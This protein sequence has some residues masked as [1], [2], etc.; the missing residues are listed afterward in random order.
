M[1]VKYRPPTPNRQSRS[2]TG[3]FPTPA[4]SLLPCLSPESY[5]FYTSFL[6]RPAQSPPMAQALSVL[7]SS[8]SSFTRPDTPGATTK[9]K[10][11]FAP[12]FFLS[13]SL[14][15]WSRPSTH[16]R[17]QDQEMDH[18]Q[19]PLVLLAEPGHT[20]TPARERRSYS[21]S[22]KR[23]REELLKIQQERER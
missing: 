3:F 8:S 21:K 5:F 9:K 1:C 14:Y 2:F 11:T 4:R 20:S 18:W 12:Q 7:H 17:T 13:N 6:P 23:K 15:P 10:N 19:V 16:A 22:S